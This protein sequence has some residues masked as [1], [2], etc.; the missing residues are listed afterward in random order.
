MKVRVYA[1][2]YDFVTCWYLGI[3][4]PLIYVTHTFSELIKLLFCRAEYVFCLGFWRVLS[5]KNGLENG[6]VRAFDGCD[7]L[8]IACDLKTLAQ[9]EVVQHLVTRTNLSAHTPS[10]CMTA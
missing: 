8:N 5:A 3:G 6:H 7:L 2:A 1:L 9:P 10:I 4:G